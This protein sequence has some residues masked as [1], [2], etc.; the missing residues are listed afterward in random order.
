M[1]DSFFEVEHSTD[2]Q[3]SLVKFCELQD[4]S[5]RM[6][7]VADNRRRAEFEDKRR[8]VAVKSIKDRVSFWGYDLLVKEYELEAL[9]SSRGFTI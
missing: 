1:P 4:F 3:N 2:V 9:K 5:A 6:V 8:R 7:I